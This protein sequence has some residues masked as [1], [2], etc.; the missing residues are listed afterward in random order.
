MGK[1]SSLTET[2][3]YHQPVAMWQGTPLPGG[4]E[5]WPNVVD[6]QPGLG[7]SED[8]SVDGSATALAEAWP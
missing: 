8:P 5:R 2:Y 4:S 1:C 3:A 6:R 7:L